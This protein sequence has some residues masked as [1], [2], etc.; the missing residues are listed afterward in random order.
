MSLASPNNPKI[1]IFP[2]LLLKR[3]FCKN[4]YETLAV[5]TKI[6][7]RTKKKQ[8]KLPKNRSRNAI[9]K[10]IAKNLPKI[11]FCLR[12]GLPKPAQNLLRRVTTS[13]HKTLWKKR[14]SSKTLKKKPIKIFGK[15]K[16]NS[17]N[18]IDAEFKS[19]FSNVEFNNLSTDLSNKLPYSG[20]I[21]IYNSDIEISDCIFNSNY[22]DL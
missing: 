10:S 2:P 4:P 19:N 20:G 7:V 6:K 15:S 5:R 16:G 13:S 17:I 22:S 8:E 18:I 12:F 11:D 21:N 14:L 1:E 3:R 9:E